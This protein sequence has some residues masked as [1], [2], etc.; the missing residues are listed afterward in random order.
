M[1]KC[2][3]RFCLDELTL[4][5]LASRLGIQAPTLY[6]H[7]KSKEALINEMATFVLVEARS[8][9]NPPTASD[10]WT[11]WVL[12]FGQALRSNLLK[13]RDGGRV[14]PARA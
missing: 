8:H 11:S 5:R 9:F 3:H 13:Y 2:C 6:W 10:D 1:M 7:F 14:W 4:R 12:A